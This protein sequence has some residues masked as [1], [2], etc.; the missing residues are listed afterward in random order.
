M[1]SCPVMSD[2]FATPWTAACQASLSLTISRS[3]SKFMFIA[4]MMPFSHLILWHSLLLLPL[5]FPNIGDFISEPVGHI[6]WP[7]IWSFNCSIS[8]S[9]EYSGLIS[10]KID[11]FALLAAQGTLRHIL[12]HHHSKA[13]L[14]WCSAFF[15]VQLSQTYGTTGKTIALTIWIFV[16]RVPFLLF[17][18]CLGLS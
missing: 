17:N 13:S 6:R 2:S 14:L 7:K 16:S 18:T 9:N 5:I 1:F 3:L 8:S 10:L 11:W 12:Q 4:S 15:T